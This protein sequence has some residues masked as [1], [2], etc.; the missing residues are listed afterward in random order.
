MPTGAVDKAADEIEAAIIELGR[1]EIRSQDIGELVMDRLMH[2]DS[3]AF[4]RYASVYRS[5]SD[6]AEFT[7]EVDALR[8]PSPPDLQVASQL[9]F[10]DEPLPYQA[11][12]K[13]RPSRS[14]PRSSSRRG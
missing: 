9:S 2:M 1:A 3:V 6:I 10:L 4:I 14:R 11:R 5:F 12:R 8:S 7:A 13:R